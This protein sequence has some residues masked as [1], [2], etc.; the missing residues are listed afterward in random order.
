MW[1]QERDIIWPTELPSLVPPAQSRP[2]PTPPRAAPSQP[3][4]PAAAPATSTSPPA[5]VSS[6]K[7]GGRSTWETLA[8][9]V[10]GWFKKKQPNDRLKDAGKDPP[11]ADWAKPVG[12]DF[13]EPPSRSPKSA[14][15]A[16]TDPSAAEPDRDQVDCTVYAP[17]AVSP[18]ETI[19]IQAMLHTP[20]EARLAAA[21]AKEFDDSATA[22]GARALDTT[23]ARGSKVA[24]QLTAPGLKIDDAAPPPIIWLGHPEGVQFGVTAPDTFPPRTVICTV[25]VTLESVPIGQIK[26]K[27][28]VQR[29]AAAPVAPLMSSS[30]QPAVERQPHTMTRYQMVFISYA[31]ADRDE[32]LKRVQMLKRFNVNFFQDVLNLEPGERWEQSLYKHI[33]Q[34]DLFLLFW[35]SA[36]KNSNWV[37]EEVKY[38]LARRG[39]NEAEAP[40]IVPIVLEGPP[41]PEPLPELS[42]LHF[43]DQ[44]LHFVANRYL[45]AAP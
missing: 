20:A 1:P 43:N 11:L 4:L 45:P 34:S 17:Q 32:V 42:H 13:V 15:R 26:F 39:A 27:L 44:I 36:A 38:A 6:S 24:F 37:R 25:L 30:V 28:S 8:Q 31:S 5:P 14:E 3:S 22:R 9:K 19:M 40:E 21:M 41:V 29:S 7:G 23:I 16:T 10:G 2:A 35:S 18:G 33:D 12:A